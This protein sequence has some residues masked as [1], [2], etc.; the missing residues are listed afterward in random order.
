MPAAEL[1]F[2]FQIIIYVEEAVQ[3]F[4]HF[5]ESTRVSE[6]ETAYAV[7]VNTEPEPFE[8]PKLLSDHESSLSKDGSPQSQNNQHPS[9]A[10]D[11][12][13][14]DDPSCSVTDVELINLPATDEEALLL[15]HFWE[16][17]RVYREN[18]GHIS[19]TDAQ[20]SDSSSN[21]ESASSIDSMRPHRQQPTTEE[22]F[23]CENISATPSASSCNVDNVCATEEDAELLLYFWKSGRVLQSHL[24]QHDTSSSP[25]DDFLKQNYPEI[26]QE[27]PLHDPQCEYDHFQRISENDCPLSEFGT[28]FIDDV[29]NDMETRK[30]SSSTDQVPPSVKPA[31]PS[32]DN[33]KIYRRTHFDPIMTTERTTE[34]WNEAYQRIMH[35]FHLEFYDKEYQNY[36]DF[37]LPS[38]TLAS[39]QSISAPPP[40]PIS[41]SQ[42]QI[43]AQSSTSS[44]AVSDEAK[45]CWRSI[46]DHLKT[47]EHWNAGFLEN[48]RHMQMGAEDDESVHSSD[49]FST[50]EALESQC[51]AAESHL[52][53]IQPSGISNFK[54]E[55]E[56]IHKSPDLKKSYN[57]RTL[58]ID[59]LL[60]LEWKDAA[61]EPTAKSEV[62]FTHVSPGFS[63]SHERNLSL[64]SSNDSCGS[65][66][67]VSTQ[68]SPIIPSPTL[69]SS[70][71][72]NPDS[73]LT[74]R[75]ASLVNQK[76]QVD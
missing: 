30:P 64:G 65:L 50:I 11:P 61:R 13:R 27:S 49:P 29:A 28:Q 1:L 67:S 52:E 22:R 60:G 34:D 68:Q 14:G 51:E 15:L 4:I 31:R 76:T 37:E 54:E 58:S 57:W 10:N 19:L 44:N 25:P 73:H 62:G 41:D 20:R 23:P 16:S 35:D 66:S 7:L 2:V 53:F 24:L 36:D 21:L 69:V 33:P 17:E 5:W 18:E 63:S 40:P 43:V 72:F 8:S 70:A 26:E 12:R 38:S 59:S 6:Q 47:I 45:A 46:P 56:D 32:S 3:L 55:F 71:T 48:I 42:S 39:Q 74:Y 75:S 9:F